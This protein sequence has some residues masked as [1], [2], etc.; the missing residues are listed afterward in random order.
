MLT[1]NQS[2]PLFLFC[3][4]L[5]APAPLYLLNHTQ[6]EQPFQSPSFSL[7]L[8]TSTF[9]PPEARILKGCV[10]KKLSNHS[11]NPSG[12]SMFNESLHQRVA[13]MHIPKTG[14][15]S[16]KK[17]L[18]DFL[19]TVKQR[20]ASPIALKQT[21]FEYSRLEKM[22]QDGKSTF[23]LTVLRHPVSYHLS[24]WR[25]K[26]TLYGRP[27]PNSKLDQVPGFNLSRWHLPVPEYA[28]GPHPEL[29]WNDQAAWMTGATI[30]FGKSLYPEA[31]VQHLRQNPQVMLET[32]INHLDSFDWVGITNHWDAS[33]ALLMH[34]LGITDQER[35]VRKNNKK[36]VPV[37]L[38]LNRS[39]MSKKYPVE[40]ETDKKA[41]ACQSDIDMQLFYFAEV[42]F[43]EQLEQCN[44][45]DLNKFETSPG[46][47][48]TKQWLKKYFIYQNKTCTTSC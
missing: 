37:N 35:P 21:H 7:H 28:R 39:P 8:Q 10:R 43:I 41:L 5:L 29:G 20:A 19:I 22:L 25:Y 18:E 30:G 40:D 11:S 3:I 26:Q 2:T 17:I 33:L 31:T 15:T 16:L 45:Y 48:F 14:G 27:P 36:P 44:C 9:Y 24:N 34:Q 6:L 42:R 13:F 46:R 12:L 1:P 32:A 38:H 23:S 47:K 4:L